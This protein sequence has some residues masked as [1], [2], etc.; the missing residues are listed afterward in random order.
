MTHV[1]DEILLND[2]QRAVVEA[3]IG[4]RLLV[5]AG[6]GQGKTEVVSSRIQFLVSEEELS[7]SSEILVLSFSRAAVTAVRTR[8]ESRDV[9]HVNV[10]TFDSFAGQLLD[11]AGIEPTGSFDARIRQATNVLTKGEETP[12]LIEDLRHVILD[13]VQDLVGDRAEFV[14]AI[15]RKLDE[16]SG[17]T[18][19]G[20]PL[21]GIYDFQLRDSVSKRTSTEVFE[22]LTGEVGAREVALGRNYRAQG[23]DPKR[24]VE[25]GDKLRGISDADEAR[26]LLDEFELT[27]L[28]L[29][30]LEEWAEIAVQEQ[31]TSAILCATNGEVL[32]VS[33]Y[34]NGIGVR[35]AVRRQAQDFGAARWVAPA[36]R[37]LE[38]PLVAR[39]EVEEE[40]VRILGEND[41]ED[42]WYLLKSVEADSRNRNQLN[43]A[44][45][46]NRIKAGA[47]PLTLTEPDGSNLIVSTV[48]RAK[49]LEF[50][51]VFLIDQSYAWKDAD[52]WEG[53][54]A[55]YVALSR[56]RDE[57]YAGCLPRSRSIFEE[58]YRARGRLCERVWAGGKG[59]GK[60]ARAVEF[61]YSDVEASAPVRTQSIEAAELQRDLQDEGL[62]GSRIEAQLDIALSTIER[63]VYSL[64]TDGG[65]LVGR[66]SEGFSE[67]FTKVF[68][69]QSPWPAVLTGLSL[70]S[71][72]TVAGEPRHTAETGLGESGM[73]LVPRVIG[74][75]KPD[76][77]V[78]EDVS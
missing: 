34:L 31:A 47:I 16:E 64:V 4:E 27:L 53:V 15:L 18:A 56:A 66:T 62:I 2:E 50:D 7:A 40:L 32:R 37:N 41:A 5:I 19:L 11:D 36:M 67:A 54:R 9:S 71:V 23:D 69:S 10:R 73:W 22:F 38:G 25:L 65:R 44:R 72:E 63:P 43:L 8:L 70:V 58:H 1:Q 74:L 35:H 68:R 51:R 20:D 76:W 57:I 13:E 17:V 75:A 28:S 61:C 52:P 59:K 78:M 39:S 26:N 33:E 55:R 30:E 60:R 77:N 29:G 21:Q 42:N 46:R 48:H 12:Y 49:G 3:P 24:V 45:V 14:Q 6:A